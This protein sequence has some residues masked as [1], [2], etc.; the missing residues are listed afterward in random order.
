M[1]LSTITVSDF[2][3]LF[4]RDFTYGTT[5]DTVMDADITRA[6]S[7]AKANFNQGLFD[8]DDTLKLAYLYLT[9]HYM[10]LDIRGSIAGIAG[11]GEYSVASKSAGSVSESYAIPQAYMDNPLLSYLAKTSYGQKYLSIVLPRLVGNI[12]AVAGWT[13]P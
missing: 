9:A 10:V 6:F 8:S 13:M 3:A 11:G 5:T 2:K 12:G 4:V 7:E 1:D